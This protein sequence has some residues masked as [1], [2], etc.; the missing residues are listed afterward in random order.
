MSVVI[1]E[2]LD[3]FRE[4]MLLAGLMNEYIIVFTELAYLDEEIVVPPWHLR[5]FGFDFDK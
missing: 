4:L 1:L 3:I 2:I 5:A